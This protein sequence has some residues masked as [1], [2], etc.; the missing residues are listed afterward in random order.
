MKEESTT[1]PP[2]R[3]TPGAAWSLHLHVSVSV[4]VSVNSDV[5]DSHLLI[6]GEGVGVGGSDALTSSFLSC[7]T[8]AAQINAIGRRLMTSIFVRLLEMVSEPEVKKRVLEATLQETV[9]TDG[10]Q[11]TD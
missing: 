7:F 8:G 11:D 4:S 3:Q 2:L 5:N 1:V 6:A 9:A 10:A